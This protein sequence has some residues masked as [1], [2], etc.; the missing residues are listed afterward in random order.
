MSQ[1][2]RDFEELK[3]YW[4]QK[5]KDSGFKDAENS[6]GFL[7]DRH[8]DKFAKDHTK[9]EYEEKENYFRYAGQL[10]HDYEFPNSFEKRV[11]ELHCTGLSLR[12][13][14]FQLRNRGNQVNKDNVQKITSKYGRL[15]RRKILNH[16]EEE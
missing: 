14:A 5:L 6:R 7:K 1:G 2:D 15:I 3:A 16:H 13:I 10:L 11:W 8:V 12:E 4:Y 9:Q